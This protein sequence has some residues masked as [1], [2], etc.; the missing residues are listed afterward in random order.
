MK[1]YTTD[2]IRNVVILGHGSA[3]KTTLT[4]SMCYLAGMTSKMGRVEDGNTISDFDKEEQKRG[5]SI[6]T[7]VLPIEWNDVKINILDTPG[8]FDFVGEVEQA[9]SVADGAIIVVSGKNGI[10]VGTEKAWEL[11]EKYNVPRIIFVT[12]MDIDN[13]SYRE[14]IENLTASYGKK[15]APFN[16][17]IREN[18]KFTGYVNVIQE[19]AFKWEGKDAVP[20]DTP[21]YSQEYLKEYRD[22]LW[23]PWQRP[24]TNSWNAI[25]R[26]RHSP[27]RRSVPPYARMCSTAPSYL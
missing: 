11:C 25:L 10:Q 2:R 15:I 24:A 22:A 16:F 6:S 3:G 23:K 20:C 18:E 4:E 17:P 1:V 8:Y 27:K 5:I 9:I 14:V 21:D 7:S 12:D 13:A 26:G 19:K